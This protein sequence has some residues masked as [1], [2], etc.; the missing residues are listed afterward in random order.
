[1]TELAAPEASED[2][3]IATGVSDVPRHRMLMQGDLIVVDQG[4]IC[5]V[6]HACSMRR[7]PQLHETQLVA[8][9]R[10]HHVD[11]WR[12]HYDWMPLPG[13]Q[14]SGLKNPATCLR[15]LWSEPTANLQE[16]ERVAVMAETGV[17]L[18]QQRMAFHLCRVV[19]DLRELAEHSA[20]V[21]AEA[22]LHEQWIEVLG[23]EREPEFHELLD[24][25][26]RKLR[27]WLDQTHTRNQAMREV[28]K[29]IASRRV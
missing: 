1:M 9:L 4:P 24:A 8:P 22:E 3:W 11:D 6:S 5:I 17:H 28:R 13:V 7:G 16:G 29:Q 20:P 15:Q 27:A 23:V 21:L 26:E 19:I 18:L 10:D 25:D 14:V 2:L 12:G